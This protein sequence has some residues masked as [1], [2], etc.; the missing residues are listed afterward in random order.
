MASTETEELVKKA[1]MLAVHFMSLAEY[2]YNLLRKDTAQKL[3]AYF[4]AVTQLA[5]KEGATTDD[6]K[7]MIPAMAGAFLDLGMVISVRHS[8]KKP[9]MPPSDHADTMYR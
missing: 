4:A 2:S 9:E 6:I 5:I 7:L 1:E 3:E 8:D